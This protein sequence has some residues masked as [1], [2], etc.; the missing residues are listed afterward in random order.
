M[1]KIFLLIVAF[2]LIAGTVKQAFA[3]S[4]SFFQKFRGREIRITYL[5]NDFKK[6]SVWLVVKRID[7][8]NDILEGKSNNGREYIQI[9]QIVEVRVDEDTTHHVLNPHRDY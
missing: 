2:F 4:P 8:N 9:Q 6:K 1:K 7:F 3:Y 5:L